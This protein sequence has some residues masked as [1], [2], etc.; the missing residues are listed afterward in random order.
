MCLLEL[1][2]CDWRLDCFSLTWF[3]YP[4]LYTDIINTEWSLNPALSYQLQQCHHSDPCITR[5]ESF[6]KSLINFDNI[7]VEI[8]ARI[9]DYKMATWNNILQT[10]QLQ[11]WW[12]I[13]VITKQKHI[14]RHYFAVYFDIEDKVA[15]D[16]DSQ[17][18][19]QAMIGDA[20]HGLR[21]WCLNSKPKYDNRVIYVCRVP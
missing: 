21:K 2:C 13:L 5:V 3:I 11:W 15:P 6:Y 7:S 8:F 12:F 18:Q 16:L 10:S 1:L 20:R 17:S 14:R 19:T 4:V 9:N